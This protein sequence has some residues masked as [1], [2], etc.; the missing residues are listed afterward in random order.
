[1]VVS[2]YTPYTVLV[3]NAVTATP[4]TL[5]IGTD[6][7]LGRVLGNIQAIAIDNDLSSV[8]ASM[9]TLAY[10]KAVKAYI[11]LVVTGALVYQSGYN[12]NTNTPDLDTTPIAGIKKG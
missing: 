6:T 12:A 3:D 5:G 9:D 8:S 10:A 1:M 2:L 4:E 11:D 7:V